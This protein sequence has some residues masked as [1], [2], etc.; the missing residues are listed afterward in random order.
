MPSLISGCEISYGFYEQTWIG[1]PD[2]VW[3]VAQ[4]V[5]I[6]ANVL[7]FIFFS[8]TASALGR[9]CHSQSFESL[10]Y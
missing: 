7:N 5:A 6:A 2:Q 9:R 4:F 10:R 3:K 1:L 8:F